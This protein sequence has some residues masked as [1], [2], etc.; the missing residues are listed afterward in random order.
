[1]RVQVPAAI[2]PLFLVLLLAGG[3]AS[4]QDQSAPTAVLDAP[5]QLTRG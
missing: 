4:S 5:D 3:P 1:M 2:R